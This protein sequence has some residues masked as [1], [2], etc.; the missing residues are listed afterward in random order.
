MAYASKVKSSGGLRKQEEAAPKDSEGRLQVI[1]AEGAD[2]LRLE[3][4]VG[5]VLR[6]GSFLS[7]GI[8]LVGVV[9]ML[10]AFFFNGQPLPGVPKPGDSASL[11]GLSGLLSGLRA[12]DPST[13]ISLGLLVLIATPVIRVATTVVYFFFKRDRMYLA[14]TT[15]VLLVLIAGFLVGAEG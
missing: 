2:G 12:K 3:E 14:I 5:Y 10:W 11:E 7:V 1:P 15:F 13:V 8:I 4:A 9:L 6:Y